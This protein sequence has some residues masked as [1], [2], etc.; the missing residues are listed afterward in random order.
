MYISGLF[1]EVSVEGRRTQVA[2]G[3]VKI[4]KRKGMCN[5]PV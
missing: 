4:G 2:R 3:V 1:D 5:G